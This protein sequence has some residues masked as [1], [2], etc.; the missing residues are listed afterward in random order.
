MSRGWVFSPDGRS[1]VSHHS[2]VQPQTRKEA[3]EHDC[4]K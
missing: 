1:S 3:S 4:T 2:N